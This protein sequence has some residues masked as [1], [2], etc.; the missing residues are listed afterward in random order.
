MK[1]IWENPR[2]L[3]L[4]LHHTNEGEGVYYTTNSKLRVTLV[5]RGIGYLDADGKTVVI[6]QPCNIAIGGSTLA[7]ARANWEQH[8]NEVHPGKPQIGEELDFGRVS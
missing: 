5:C 3:G 6:T 8:C 4:E 1:K 7:E 2:V